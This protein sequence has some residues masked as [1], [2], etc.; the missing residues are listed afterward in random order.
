MKFCDKLLNLRK[1]HNMSQ[2]QL[3]DKLGISRQAVSKW[4]SASSLPDMDKIMQLCKILNCSLEELVDDDI[5]TKK[6]NLVKEK[7]DFTLYLK[8][9]LDFV[10]KTFNMFWSMRLFEKI[11]CIVEMVFVI[12]IFYIIWGIGGILI[13]DLFSN[14]LS[15]LPR[16]VNITISYLWHFIYGIFG[17]AAGSILTIHIFKIRYLDY[18]ITIEDGNTSEKKIEAP[19]EENVSSDDGKRKFIDSKKNKIII[20]DPKHTPY[21]FFKLLSR[22]VMFFVKIILIFIAFPCVLSIVFLIFFATVSLIFIKDGIFFLAIFITF[23]G[24]ILLNYLLLKVLYDFIF[25][26]KENWR[27]IFNIF[28]GAISIV[29]IGIGIS[30]AIYL[31]FEKVDYNLGIS[32]ITSIELDGNVNETILSFLENDNVQI[33][34]DNNLTNPRL[35]IVHNNLKV[36]NL[37]KYDYYIDSINRDYNIYDLSFYYKDDVVDMVN[38]FIKNIKK[39]KRVDESS[40]E[41]KLYASKEKVTILENNLKI[42]N[43]D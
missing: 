22:W 9:I 42:Y 15:L 38:Y 40:Y 14:I 11:V 7:V 20:R 41:V 25:N 2:E 29:G 12:L 5:P 19:I 32:K 24:F 17:F 10:T 34:E 18:F 13:S 27:W 30:F 16:T 28:I 8:E 4:E 39:K 21:S 26:L 37:C 33:I 6:D 23:L 36:P 3:A 1:K 31:G 43:N 35:E